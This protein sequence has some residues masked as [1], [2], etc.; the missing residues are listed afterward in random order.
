MIVFKELRVSSDSKTLI[1]DVEVPEAYTSNIEKIYVDSGVPLGG[2]CPAY[3]ENKSL[4]AT[5]DSGEVQEGK[6]VLITNT[7]AVRLELTEDNLANP[8][9]FTKDMLH[10]YVELDSAEDGDCQIPMRT[11]VDLYPIYRKAIYYM[12]EL[13]KVCSTPDE[14]ED[15]I[16]RIN[17]VKMALFTGNYLVAHQMWE[18]IYKLH[19]VPFTPKRCGCDGKV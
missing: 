12:Q 1:I 13:T 2:D 14:L 5:T 17:S 8:V 15:L 11:V 6:T 4:V 16:L 7:K 3:T 19:S 18:S 9:S 10:V